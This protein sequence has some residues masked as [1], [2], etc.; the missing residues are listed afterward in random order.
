[1]NLII[2]KLESL[3]SSIG[4]LNMYFKW[5]PNYH[6]GGSWQMALGRGHNAEKAASSNGALFLFIFSI[7]IL[8]AIGFEPKGK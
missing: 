5:K 8:G 4:T 2:L 6:A 3:R 7:S 1:M